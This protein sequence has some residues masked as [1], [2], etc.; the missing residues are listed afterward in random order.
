MRKMTETQ[1]LHRLLK[2]IYR[3]GKPAEHPSLMDCDRYHCG[4]DDFETCIEYGFLPEKLYGKNSSEC[5]DETIDEW[6]NDYIWRTINSP[7]DC[8]GKLFTRWISWHRNPCGRISFV[9]H[10]GIDI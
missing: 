6:I 4:E 9:H 5:L 7:Y 2:K 10:L 3:Q 1:K 8:T